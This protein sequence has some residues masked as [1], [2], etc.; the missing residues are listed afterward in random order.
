LLDP[1]LRLHAQPRL[2]FAGQMTGCEGYVESAGV[3]LLAG[4]FAAADATQTKIAPPP[5]TT[6]LGALLGH[7]TGGH[8]ETID[9]GPRSFQPMNINFGLFPPL[10]SPP[11][12]KP[13]GTRLRGN[14]KTVAKKQAMSAR[15][16]SDL[17]RWI[18]E[19]LRVS[20]AA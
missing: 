8:I 19:T 18:A 15:A 4:L 20:N 17:D 14:E 9:A 16:L 7:I 2:R 12:K 11:T 6:A 1:Q 3:G 5:P 10:A 13:D